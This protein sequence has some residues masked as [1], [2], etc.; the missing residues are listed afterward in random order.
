MFSFSVSVKITKSDVRQKSKLPATER[1][2][3]C[4]ESQS[5]TKV[6]LQGNKSGEFEIGFS[7]GSV[8]LTAR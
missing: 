3:S 1:V 7:F 8:K 2:I 5:E 4:S 6:N